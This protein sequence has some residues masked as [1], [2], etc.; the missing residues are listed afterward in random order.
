MEAA[1]E[2]LDDSWGASGIGKSVG[3]ETWARGGG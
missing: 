2:V 1:F 3:G